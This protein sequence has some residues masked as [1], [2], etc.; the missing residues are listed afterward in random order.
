M[1][2]RDTY[3]N[4]VEET[5]SGQGEHLTAMLQ[6]FSCSEGAHPAIIQSVRAKLALQVASESYSFMSSIDKAAQ[7]YE[8]VNSSVENEFSASCSA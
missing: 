6:L 7:Y 4:M 5:A 1:F 2:I 8:A 3:P